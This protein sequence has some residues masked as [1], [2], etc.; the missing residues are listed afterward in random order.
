V[1]HTVQMN[2][3]EMESQVMPIP[4][5]KFIVPY[6][7]G[8]VDYQFSFQSGYH[9]TGFAYIVS[10]LDPLQPSH[11]RLIELGKNLPAHN[12]LLDRYF[13]GGEYIN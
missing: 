5:R 2:R 11:R 1:N 12:L 3:K 9:S 10:R 8:C 7:V 6:F 13:V 4:D